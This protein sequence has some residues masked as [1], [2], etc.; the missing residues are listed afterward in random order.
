MKKK[1]WVN[2]FEVVG[3]KP[4]VIVMPGLGSLNLADETLPLEKVEK[5][6]QAGCPYLKLIVERPNKN[7][8]AKDKSD[9]PKNVKEVMKNLDKVQENKVASSESE[10]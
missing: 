3:I 1:F 9:Y 4:G 2:K 5:A 7:Q 8:K 10:S 6:F